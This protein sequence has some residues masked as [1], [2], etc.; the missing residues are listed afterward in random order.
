MPYDPEDRIRI[1]D[2]AR[3]CGVSVGTIRNWEAAGK[4]TAQRTATEQRT[5]RRGDVEAL[6]EKAAS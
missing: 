5:F 3:I 1:G 2:A 4:L 6:A